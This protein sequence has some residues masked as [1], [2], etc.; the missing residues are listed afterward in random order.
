MKAFDDSCH[1]VV[2]YRRGPE[3]AK[4]SYILDWWYGEIGFSTMESD[5]NYFLFIYLNEEKLEEI[6]EEFG[7]QPM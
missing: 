4:G 7:L 2:I 5:A 1:F 6:C 3:K